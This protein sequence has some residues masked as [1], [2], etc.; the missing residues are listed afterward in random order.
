MAQPEALPIF[1]G[2]LDDPNV[3]LR[4]QAIVMLAEALQRCQEPGGTNCSVV[5]AKSKQISSL[6][7]KAILT[8]DEEVAGIQAFSICG[9]QE[10]LALLDEMAARES[11]KKIDLSN[12]DALND[13]RAGIWLIHNAEKKIKVREASKAEKR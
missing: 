12:Q 10:D 9:T 13:Q 2:M 5:I 6:I 1:F 7:H 4:N 8:P 3:G 11:K